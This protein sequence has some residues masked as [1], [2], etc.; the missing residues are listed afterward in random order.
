MLLSD[1][2]RPSCIDNFSHNHHIHKRLKLIIS[3]KDDMNNCIFYGNSGVGKY[4][5]VIAML[6]EL[7]DDSVYMLKTVRRTI[8]SKRSL[9]FYVKQSIHH[10]ELD[11]SDYRNNDKL[12]ICDYVNE[13][14]KTSNII[15]GG[16]RVIVIK[17]A[18]SLSKVAQQSLRY[19]IERHLSTTRFIFITKS[20]TRIIDP[21]KSRCTQLRLAV[22]SN[23]EI[24][25]I[26][27]HIIT[28]EQKLYDYNILGDLTTKIVNQIIKNCKIIGQVS[29]LSIAI[30]LLNKYI[31]TKDMK[32]CKID[33]INNYN[34]VLKYITTD[35]N[36]ITLTIINNLRNTLY[37]IYTTH[38]DL[39]QLITYI[40]HKL[41]HMDYDTDIKL[42]ITYNAAKYQHKITV[43]D[44]PMIHTE[45]FMFSIIGLI[46]GIE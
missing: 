36:N 31:I 6:A 21:I 34:Q 45:A 42:Q 20:L 4:S 15:T 39:S 3:N 8:S 28:E 11:L 46:N 30:G 18:Q 27:T 44:K 16:F 19:I 40:S 12:I 23:E 38:N 26:L 43:S 37:L 10:I 35:K 7:F 32:L 17:N 14:C 33:S 2:Y 1:K 24:S 13:V 41:I 5:Y 9:S 25:S 22:P 29:N